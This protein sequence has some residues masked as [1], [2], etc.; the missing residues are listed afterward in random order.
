L[1]RQ[2]IRLLRDPHLSRAIAENGASTSWKSMDAKIW[3]LNYFSYTENVEAWKCKIKK[4]PIREDLAFSRRILTTRAKNSLVPQDRVENL[5]VFILTRN[6][7]S[8]NVVIN[9]VKVFFHSHSSL[10]SQLDIDS[11]HDG[12]IRVR[13][14][15]KLSPQA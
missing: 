3:Q 6:K 10:D 2:I 1:A 8:L 15:R 13:P 14:I 12:R 11:N 4:R 5:R 7:C 9:E